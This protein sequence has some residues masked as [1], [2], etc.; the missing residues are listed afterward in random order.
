MEHTEMTEMKNLLIQQNQLLQKQLKTARL[1]AL[2]SGLMALA[3]IVTGLVLVPR[4][5][6]MA[7]S[8]EEAT[9]QFSSSLASF[10]TVAQELASADIAGK[11]QDLDALVLQS[12]EAIAQAM[13]KINA[14]D[15]ETLNLAIAN[16][17]AI[18]QPLA[19]FFG[20]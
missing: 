11:L 2:L 8:V 7:A 5:N 20:R 1:S 18:I 4:L 10:E 13:D 6:A 12:Q 17:A 19:L 3:L 9:A 16:L 15:I 14:M